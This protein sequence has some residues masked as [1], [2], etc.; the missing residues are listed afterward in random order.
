MDKIDQF[1]FDWVRILGALALLSFGFT[2]LLSY[3]NFS[4]SSLRTEKDWK[5]HFHYEDDRVF[6]VTDCEDL[7]KKR[8]SAS[9][10]FYK[11]KSNDGHEVIF[12]QMISSTEAVTEYVDLASCKTLKTDEKGRA[13][14]ENLQAVRRVEP[15]QPRSCRRERSFGLEEGRLWI[16]PPCDSKFFVYVSQ[17]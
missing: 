14:C 4:Y 9:T 6:S 11:M 5:L 17:L 10:G 1:K 8:P 15:L 7:L 12:C 13:F 2:L 3:Q 16:Q